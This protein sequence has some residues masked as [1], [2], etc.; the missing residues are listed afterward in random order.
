MNTNDFQQFQQEWSA[1]VECSANGKVLSENAM[2]MI[3]E[4][5]E[6]Y[7]LHTV[8]KALAHHRTVCK[9][10][11]TLADIIAIINPVIHSQ[12]HIGAD[13]AWAIAKTGMNDRNSLVATKEIIAA[14]A[15]AY[16]VYSQRDENPARMAFRDAYNRIIRTT[17]DPPKWFLSRG[18]DRL[19]TFNVVQEAIQLGRLPN[20]TEGQQK[21]EPPTTTVTKLIEGYVRNV[22]VKQEAIS[23]IKGLLKKE[24]EKRWRD[25]ADEHYQAALHVTGEDVPP[26]L[27]VVDDTFFY[28]G[29]EGRLK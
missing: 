22:S 16:E 29:Q 20:G 18:D 19:Q 8:K 27:K 5:L 21:I 15:V 13:E 11:P 1:A 25:F 9:F 17:A 6:P 12:Q 26:N 24:P 2:G 3:F 10:A 23:A 14:I 7:S 4:D 28:G